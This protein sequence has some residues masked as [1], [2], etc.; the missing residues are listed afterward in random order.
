MN[1]PGKPIPLEK[2][3]KM[4]KSDL[5]NHSTDMVLEDS[6]NSNRLA[7]G[8]IVIL[9]FVSMIL[10]IYISVSYTEKKAMQSK[11]DSLEVTSKSYRDNL[12][13]PQSI[14]EAE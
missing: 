7:I 11:I 2:L 3:N 12:L 8:L 6:E 5:L 13:M 1:P 10:L 14:K 4:K 9:F